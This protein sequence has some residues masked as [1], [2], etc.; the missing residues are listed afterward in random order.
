M[1]T[2]FPVHLNDRGSLLIF[3]RCQSILLA[4]SVFGLCAVLC[5]R[6]RSEDKLSLPQCRLQFMTL[7]TRIRNLTSEPV[8]LNFILRNLLPNGHKLW[9]F[10]NLCGSLGLKLVVNYPSVQIKNIKILSNIKPFQNFELK[11]CSFGR[12]RFYGAG[13]WTGQCTNG[14]GTEVSTIVGLWV[15]FLLMSNVQMVVAQSSAQSLDC[16]F[17]SFSCPSKIKD[18]SY[19]GKSHLT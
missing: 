9:I 3:L 1:E 16:G 13:P 5:L 10:P 17:I 6:W 7:W 14:G 12:K 19:S 15:N 2:L 4:L 8:P 18:E 11:N